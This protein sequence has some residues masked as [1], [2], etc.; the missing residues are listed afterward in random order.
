MN[1]FTFDMKKAETLKSDLG[2]EPSEIQDLV[3]NILMF[4]DD[5][6]LNY[7][8]AKKAL[9]YANQALLSDMATTPVYGENN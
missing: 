3:R 8:Q 7:L 1:K 6:H 5:R 2:N 9:D 4:T